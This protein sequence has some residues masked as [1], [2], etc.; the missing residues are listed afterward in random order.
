M[1]KVESVE[2][3]TSINP[4]LEVVIDIIALESRKKAS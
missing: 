4:Y 3:L 1:L 2:I